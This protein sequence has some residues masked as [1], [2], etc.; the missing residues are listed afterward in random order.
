MASLIGTTNAACPFEP[1]SGSTVAIT[2]C[3]SE[4]PP[5]VAHAF[6]PFSTHSL[7]ASS[8][9]ARVRTLR[10]VRA[11]VGLRS[12]ERGHLQ[13]IGRAEAAG[14]PLA[15]L[16]AAALAEDRGHGQRGAHDRHADTGVAPEQLLVDDRQRQAGGVGEELGEPFEPVQP[17]L[18]GLLDDR[19]GGLL[20]LVPLVRGGSHH[21]GGEAVDPLADVLLVLGQRHREGRLLVGRARDRLDG[22]LGGLGIRLLRGWGDGGRG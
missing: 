3:T 10:H 20:L 6:W 2:T 13:V 12:A 7:L 17:D 19:P 1:S 22:G 18:G 5:L 15:D 8:N 9:L 16:L 21:V 11:R 4:M 14:D